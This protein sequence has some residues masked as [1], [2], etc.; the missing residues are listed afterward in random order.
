MEV[1]WGTLVMQGRAK[2]PGIPWSDAEL[3]AINEDGMSVD[4][5]RAGLLT[6]EDAN[7]ATL[8]GEK[9]LERMKKDDLVAM[10]EDL[11]LKFDPNAVTKADLILEIQ[12][13]EEKQAA[14][15]QA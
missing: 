11:G 10:A 12:S 1:D 13:A 6:P 4:D 9:K 5:V 8:S 7:N 3:K 14:P 2:A 15:A